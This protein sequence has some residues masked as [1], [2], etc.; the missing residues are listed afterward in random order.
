LFYPHSIP[1]VEVEMR[2]SAPKSS[3]ESF[4]IPSRGR[5]VAE[6]GTPHVI[7]NTD[8]VHALRDKVFDSL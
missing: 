3:F 2:V 4:P 1:N 5:F 8:N 6:E 7:V